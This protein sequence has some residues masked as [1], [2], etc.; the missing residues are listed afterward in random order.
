MG[1]RANSA[2]EGAHTIEGKV[3]LVCYLDAAGLAAEF[4]DNRPPGHPDRRKVG[5]Y[6][7]STAGE[8]Q[9]PFQ[10]SR[11]AFKDAQQKVKDQ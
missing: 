9:G 4:P 10:G 7:T 2:F 8:R 11:A 6:W 3:V 1:N 5:W